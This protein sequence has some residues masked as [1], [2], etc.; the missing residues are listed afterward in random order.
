MTEPRERRQD[1]PDGRDA[2]WTPPAPEHQPPE[3]VDQA[4]RVDQAQLPVEQTQPVDLSNTQAIPP[5]VG[6]GEPAPQP[7]WTY[8]PQPAPHGQTGWPTAQHEAG[9]PTAQGQ[10]GWPGQPGSGAQ[11]SGHWDQP[12]GDQQ[13]N[14]QQWDQG[15]QQAP[16][17]QDWTQSHHAMTQGRPPRRGPGWPALV[18][19]AVLS[20]L[21]AGLLGGLAGGWLGAN[22]RLGFGGLSGSPSPLP[23]VGSGATSRPDGSIANI[24][25]KALPSVVTIKVQGADGDGTGSGFV[26]DQQGHIITNNH[27]VAGAAGEGTIRVQLANGTEIA[28]TI[29]G[30]DSSYDIAVLKTGRSDLQPLVLGSSGDVVVGD[31]VI[32]LGAPLGLENTVTSGIVSALNRPVSPGG[33]GDEQSFINALQTDA[34]INPGNSGGPLLD[35]QGR[36]IGV[37]SAIARVPGSSGEQSGNIGVGFS[38]PVDQVR[39][40][41]DQLIRTGKAEHPVIGVILDRQYDGADGVKILEESSAQREPVTPE[42]PAGKAGVKPGDLIIEFDGR[43]VTDPDDLVVLI[44]AKSVGDEVTMKVR[45]G[46]REIS[47]RMT[48]Q[49][50]TDQ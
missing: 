40:T 38:I 26:A 23:T 13:W 32:A 48:L 27:V 37:N 45:R 1:E 20:A 25:A 8:D 18:S 10:T 41:A 2:A 15:W 7:S 42:G 9:W 49:G 19:V 47:V 5:P 16:P 30:R 17:T 36:V 4:Q 12:Q 50:N 34:A 29:A 43:R 35:M 33:D 39:K 11:A 46:S 31:H 21:L 24:A 28:A 22:D 3:S 6:A 14:H 44:R